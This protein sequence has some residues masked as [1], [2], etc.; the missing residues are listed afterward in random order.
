MASEQLKATIELMRSQQGPADADISMEQMRANMEQMQGQMEV[1]NDVETE[2]V[3]VNGVAAEW[4][5]TP[6]SGRRVL[7]YYHGGG[8][9]MGSLNTHRE[10]C[11]RL[12]RACK[13]SVL[14]VDYR[15]APEHPHP[16]AVDDAVASYRWLLDQDTDPA[17]ILMGGDSAGGGLT[18]ATL[19]RLKQEGISLPAGGLLFSPWTDLAATGESLVTRAEL[20][21][22]VDRD[23]DHQNGQGVLWRS[24]CQGSAYFAPLWRS[25]RVAAFA[26]P[27]GWRG[28]SS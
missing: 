14:N 27:S 15:L 5:R 13:A 25:H 21:P 20:D 22:M 4:I 24:E 10:F 6:E 17:R 28:S 12:S 16:A 8:Y 7:I 23:G 1:P 26:R 9:V 19:I 11:S 3:T 2:S 18:M